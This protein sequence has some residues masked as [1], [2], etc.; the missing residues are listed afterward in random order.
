MKG[1]KSVPLEIGQFFEMIDQ[2]N[3]IVGSTT[4]FN[5]YVRALSTIIHELLKPL[6][7]VTLHRHVLE[8]SH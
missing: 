7:S 1:I 2:N 3:G 4:G 8:C 6:G 5:Y